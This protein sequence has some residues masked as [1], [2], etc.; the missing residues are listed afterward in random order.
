MLNTRKN[1][2]A[3]LEIKQ[4]YGDGEDGTKDYCESNNYKRYKTNEFMFEA[5]I[6][7]QELFH[8]LTILK[9]ILN[10]SEL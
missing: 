3:Y 6:I 5:P 2:L 4:P 1:T 10:I 8:C 7:S 9:D